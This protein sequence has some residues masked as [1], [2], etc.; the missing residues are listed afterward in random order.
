MT[1]TV[2]VVV[3]GLKSSTCR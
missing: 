2:M 1:V 3:T